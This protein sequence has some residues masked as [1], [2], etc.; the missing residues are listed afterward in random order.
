MISANI[1]N[2]IF[3][4]D[5]LTWSKALNSWQAIIKKNRFS[6]GIE[7]GA[8]FGGGT[9]LLTKNGIKTVCSNVKPISEETKKIHLKH[10]VSQLI[11][12]EIIDA[13]TINYPDNHFDIV[14]MKSTLGYF[15]SDSDRIKVINEIHRILKS[16]GVFLFS[17]NMRGSLL[18]FLARK[19]LVKWGNKWNYF[20]VKEQNNLFSIFRE[21][22]IM[23]TGFFSAFFFKNKLL[24]SIF[25]RIDSLFE[26]LP[27]EFKYV[28]YGYLIK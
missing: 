18:H 5:V 16:G 23:Y 19:L 3:K 4:W 21:K 9:L 10:K 12:Y 22:K 7:L 17:E 14:F 13:R 25:S 11:N 1:I 27:N 8:N 26:F 24:Y 15:K 28:S 2:D 20:S 6:N